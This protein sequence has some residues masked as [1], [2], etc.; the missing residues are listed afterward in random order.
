MITIFLAVIF[1]KTNLNVMFYDKPHYR[2]RVCIFLLI[3]ASPL[4]SYKFVHEACY[5]KWQVK[6]YED[7]EICNG[8][9]LK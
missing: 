1:L 6:W 8:M 3:V 5:Y 4:M 7:G 9:S 2:L